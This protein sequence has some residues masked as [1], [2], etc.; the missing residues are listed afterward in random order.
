MNHKSYLLVKNLE[1]QVF[2]G[3][4]PEERA[5]KQSVSV[6]IKIHFPE[7]PVASVTDNIED[8]F[9]YDKLI[10]ALKNHIEPRQF[11]LLEFLGREIYQFVKVT[12]ANDAF[13]SVTVTKMPDISGL[14]DGVAF[15]FGDSSTP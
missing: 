7:S 9:C 8:T 3:C 10:V 6:E 12:L 4:F 15:Y 5:K 11:N 1:L 14:K 13:V 2:L